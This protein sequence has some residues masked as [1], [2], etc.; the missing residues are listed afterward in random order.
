[1]IVMNHQPH[2]V[3]CRNRVTGRPP[4]RSALPIEDSTTDSSST[5]P[6]IRLGDRLRNRPS[7]SRSKVNAPRGQQESVIR[8]RST[9]SSSVVGSRPNLLGRETNQSA[10]GALTDHRPPVMMMITLPAREQQRFHSPRSAL[11]TNRQHDNRDDKQTTGTTNRTTQGTAIGQRS[12]TAGIGIR[13]EE[14]CPAG[15]NDSCNERY[16]ST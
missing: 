4:P 5:T 15:L 12:A 6:R 3:L 10:R 8:Q 9:A 16:I 13:T 2:G 1:M 7:S 11:P 14:R